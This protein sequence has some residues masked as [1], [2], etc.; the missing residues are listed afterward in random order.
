S[1]YN[2]G[3]SGLNACVWQYSY[4]TGSVKVVA[5]GT[6]STQDAAHAHLGSSNNWGC[7]SARRLSG[8][9][10]HPAEDRARPPLSGREAVYYDGGQS[11]RH[12][13]VPMPPGRRAYAA[14]PP[15]PGLSRTLLRV[16]GRSGALA[17]VC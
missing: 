16:G 4:N 12:M 11:W 2:H 13:Q 1:W 5:S 15:G 9:T 14:E 7:P 6:S 10:A 3:T 8:P 17:H